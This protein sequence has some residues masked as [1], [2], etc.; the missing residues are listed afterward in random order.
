MERDVQRTLD[1]TKDEY[2]GPILYSCIETILSSGELLEDDFQAILSIYRTDNFCI[3]K[4]THIPYSLIASSSSLIPALV[5]AK[6]CGSAIYVVPSIF[7]TAGF[8]CYSFFERKRRRNHELV[9]ESLIQILKDIQE[10]N[11]RINK[12]LIERRTHSNKYLREFFQP[13]TNTVVEFVKALSKKQFDLHHLIISNIFSFSEFCDPLKDDCKLLK[14]YQPSTLTE[15]LQGGLDNYLK[16]TNDVI[17]VQQLLNSKMLSYFAIICCCDES[18]IDKRT[19]RSFLNYRIPFVV[20]LL[21][22]Y[23]NYI[24]EMF[25]SL[26]RTV[27]RFS[28]NKLEKRTITK[29][30]ISGKLRHAL[31]TSVNNLCFVLEKLY[32]IMDIIERSDGTTD[33]KKIDQGLIDLRSHTAA[34]YEALD[35]LCKLYG[36]LSEPKKI[37]EIQP[38]SANEE[39]TEPQKPHRLQFLDEKDPRDLIEDKEKYELY[40]KATEKLDDYSPIYEEASDTYLR[41][42][43]KELKQNL[44]QHEFYVSARERW[45]DESDE[46]EL[47]QNFNMQNSI[48]VMGEQ[49]VSESGED[50]DEEENSSY[51]GDDTETE[52]TVREPISITSSSSVR[53]APIPDVTNAIGIPIDN[54]DISQQDRNGTGDDIPLE[55][56]KEMGKRNGPSENDNEIPKLDT[57]TRMLQIEELKNWNPIVQGVKALSHNKRELE[58]T[59]GEDTESD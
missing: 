8:G 11:K 16:Y 45:R 1:L 18:M 47:P 22:D 40:L 20:K 7:L 39:N 44:Y 19:L 21:H 34:T 55:N 26:R 49:D 50:S 24:L 53:A 59:F 28:E 17:N 6:K 32:N 15:L 51:D 5:V 42:M 13:F 54:L 43:I 41:L 56:Q 27:I 29:E 57:S 58:E 3:T 38:K 9:I 2:Y 52:I 14:D 37:H 36:I 35:I 46:E 30:R 33:P 25:H 4:K 31:D 48:H 10:L 23:H 12:Y